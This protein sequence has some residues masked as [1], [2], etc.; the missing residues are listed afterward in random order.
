[1]CK[2]VCNRD[3]E[4]KRKTERGRGRQRERV[5][6]SRRDIERDRKREK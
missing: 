4:I 1:M 6:E 2:F 5:I 3:R